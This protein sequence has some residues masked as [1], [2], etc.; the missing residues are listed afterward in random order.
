MN[1]KVVA[2]DLVPLSEKTKDRGG[3]EGLERLLMCVGTKLEEQLLI[4][5]NDWPGRPSDR[6]RNGRQSH[7]KILLKKKKKIASLENAKTEFAG[8]EQQR[9]RILATG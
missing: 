7:R 8:R 2:V 3:Q 9:N 6:N 5:E 4:L 1:P